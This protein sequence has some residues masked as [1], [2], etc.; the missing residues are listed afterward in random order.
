MDYH[1]HLYNSLTDTQPHTT[2]LSPAVKCLL[3]GSGLRGTGRWSVL[4]CYWLRLALC[5]ECAALPL[6]IYKGTE[7]NSGDFW[8]AP[9]LTGPLQNREEQTGYE[10]RRIHFLPVQTV[11]R[12]VKSSTTTYIPQEM[13]QRR[14]YAQCFV[15]VLCQDLVIGL[16][17]VPAN[18]LRKKRGISFSKSSETYAKSNPAVFTHLK[19]TA[20]LCM[21]KTHDKSL[22]YV[23]VDKHTMV[24]LP[25]IWK[26]WLMQRLWET[27]WTCLCCYLP[28]LSRNQYVGQ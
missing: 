18:N 5:A 2:F 14:R 27:V 15:F 22:D 4:V 24:V 11:S 23:H 17:S 1:Q 19:P 13:L 26:M 6:A 7:V 16:Q 12:C 28:P 10:L 8:C 21:E 9:V 3:S 25:L 20:L